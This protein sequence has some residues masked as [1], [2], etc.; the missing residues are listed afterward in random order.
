MEQPELRWKR[1]RQSR[2]LFTRDKET[3]VIERFHSSSFLRSGQREPD[4]Q[5]PVMRNQAAE[6][7]ATGILARKR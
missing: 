7:A 2:F 4:R 1:R 6:A 5:T 3:S